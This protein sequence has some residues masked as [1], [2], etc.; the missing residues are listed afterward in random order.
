MKPYE[1][2]VCVCVRA[3]AQ[4]AAD[5]DDSLREVED[6]APPPPQSALLTI[7]STTALFAA[8]KCFSLAG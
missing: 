8:M 4:K 3:R 5:D 1:Q 7:R 6:G 2:T